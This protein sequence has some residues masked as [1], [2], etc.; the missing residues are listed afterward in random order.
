MHTTDELSL[1]LSLLRTRLC[2]RTP[3]LGSL[4]L[5]AEIIS[6]DTILTA[7][8]NGRQIFINPQFFERLTLD[9]QEAV[10]LHEVLHAALLHVHRGIGRHA[11]RW[12]IAA[13][14]VVNG[15]L[16]REGFAL[17][18]DSV[19]V[20]ALEQFSVEEVYDLLENPPWAEQDLLLVSPDLLLQGGMSEEQGPM[21]GSLG[22]EQARAMEAYWRNAFEQA[23]VMAETLLHGSLPASLR[24]E[25]ETLKGGQLNWRHYL[26]RYLVRTPIDF[27]DFDR[28][29]V[30]KRIY[31]ETLEGETVSVAVAVDTSGSIS[32]KQIRVFLS[33]VQ[34]ILLSYPHLDCHLY[35][36]DAALHGPY[37]LTAYADIPTPIGG[38]GTDFR[39]FF[40]KL[41]RDYSPGTTA[42]AIYL[43]DGYGDFPFQP[44]PFPVLWV[45]TPGGLD[46][47]YFPFGETVRLL[48]ES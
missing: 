19:R 28:R 18:K 17:P 31:L 36:A 2:T 3:F 39:P 44:P 8:T 20:Q 47:A 30:G 9:Q 5:F 10:L 35:Y 48:G 4:L 27:R 32:N 15:V 40:T 43:T 33:E 46:S 26:W 25:L 22:Q 37:A 6:T 41:T 1:T 11:N 16:A 38:G 21:A 7:A 13:D 14:I 12:N 45:V 42:V 23:S 29:F 24:R 34:S